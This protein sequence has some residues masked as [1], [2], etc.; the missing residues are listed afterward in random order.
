MH[1]GRHRD[2]KL[3]LF[4]M[5]FFTVRTISAMN[6]LGIPYPMHCRNSPGVV[7]T[8]NRFDQ[9]GPPRDAIPCIP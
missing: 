8:L 3:G 6:E 7:E 4:D 1:E 9:G 5:E 2:I